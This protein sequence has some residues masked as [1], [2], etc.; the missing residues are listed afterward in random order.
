VPECFLIVYT[1]DH[2]FWVAS[3]HTLVH[4]QWNLLASNILTINGMI[5]TVAMLKKLIHLHFHSNLFK[6]NLSNKQVF[7]EPWWSCARL[8][9]TAKSYRLN[10]QTA[11]FCT[12]V[13]WSNRVTEIPKR[14]RDKWISCLFPA[15]FNLH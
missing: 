15:D 10:F 7:H 1:P 4:S 3:L 8:C 6:W 13:E 12:R 2:I 5:C 11:I 14:Q 9:E